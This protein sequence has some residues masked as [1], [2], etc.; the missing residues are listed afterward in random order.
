MNRE[1]QMFGLALF[2]SFLLVIVLFGFFFGFV[3][4]IIPSHNS[5]FDSTLPL[6]LPMSDSVKLQLAN[7]Y[8]FDNEYAVCVDS[9]SDD[10]FDIVKVSG[11]IV[12]DDSSVDDV[13]CTSSGHLHSHINGDCSPSNSDILSWK[14]MVNHGVVIFYIQCAPNKFAVYTQENFGLGVTYEI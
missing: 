8:S 7:Y 14:G 5:N 1:N 11:Y 4:I 3:K 12:G 13:F 2:V 9:K 10:L 6:V